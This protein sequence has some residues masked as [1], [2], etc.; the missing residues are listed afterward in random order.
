[1]KK[2][3]GVLIERK[4]GERDDYPS[5]GYLVSLYFFQDYDIYG[6]DPDE[7]VEVFKFM[8]GKEY[9]VGVPDDIHRFISKYGATEKELEEAFER[10]FHPEM[11][12]YGWN[13]RTLQEAL[14]KI[15]EIMADPANPGRP[16][17]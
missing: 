10:V 16:R 13:G 15:A 2:M 9:T 4:P 11:Q 17:P 8:N 3:R 14:N 12:I 7:I 5:L 6:E 1:M